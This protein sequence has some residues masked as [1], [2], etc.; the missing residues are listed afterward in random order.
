MQ[1][2]LVLRETVGAFGQNCRRLRPRTPG[3]WPPAQLGA[4]F[5]R[6]VRG[7]PNQDR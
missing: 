5:S 7:R 2:T 1:D 3:Y 6:W 4:S